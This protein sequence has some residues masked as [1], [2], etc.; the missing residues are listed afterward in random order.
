METTTK[1]KV[2]VVDDDD[3]LRK[4]LIDQLEVSGYV[5]S[6]A[7]M[8]RKGCIRPLHGILIDYA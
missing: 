3:N 7:S 4:V 8:A 2:L 1:K 5:T 6:G